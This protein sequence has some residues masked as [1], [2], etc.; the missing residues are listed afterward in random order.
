MGIIHENRPS[1]ARIVL[2]DT[3]ELDTPVFVSVF[4]AVVRGNGS[5]WAIPFGA[6]TPGLDAFGDKPTADG[7]G[8][9]VRQAIVHCGRSNVISVP[10]NQHL[11]FGVLLQGAQDAVQH[12]FGFGQD[13]RTFR[14]RT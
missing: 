5:A 11:D 3:L 13:G 9:G 8:A 4:F 7:F 14:S 12:D 10:T 1:D 6:H 2:L